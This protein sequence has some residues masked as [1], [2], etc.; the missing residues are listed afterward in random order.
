MTYSL[1]DYQAAANTIRSRTAIVPR[2]GLILGSGLGGLADQVEQAV[3]IDGTDIPNWPR[4]TVEGHKGRVVVGTL[5]GQS[6]CV[7]QGRAHFYEGNTMAQATFPVRVMQQ[8]GIDTLIVTN[9]AGGLNPAFVA[10]D[11]MLITDHINFLG[12]AGV[13]PLIGPNDPVLGPRFPGLVAAYD[14]D[15]AD[16]A[17][18]VAK[19]QN[20]ALKEGVYVALSGPFFETPAEVRMLRI[21]GGDAVGM[22]TAPEVVVARHAGMRVLGFSGITNQAIDSNRR[23]RQTNHAEVIDVGDR[24]IVP[25]LSKL[26][27]GVLHALPVRSVN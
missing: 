16:A 24:L 20:I 6:V 14:L 13:N 21:I 12:M 17:R 8:L 5:E 3:A 11:L 19:A 22:S 9:A 2:V 18:S 15:L 7:I 27:L 4:S 1:A 23:D 10:G 25:A 26:L